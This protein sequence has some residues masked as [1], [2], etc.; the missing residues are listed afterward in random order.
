MNDINMWISL[1][2]AMTALVAVIVGPLIS[3]R[4]AKREV[5]SPIRQ[6]WINVLRAKLAEIMSTSH[7]FFVAWP[8]DVSAESE[9][10]ETETHKKMLFLYREIE[11]MLNPKEHDHT[12]LL[13][14]LR[15]ITFEVNHRET[16]AKYSNIMGET[17]AI[18]QKIFKDE[19]TRVK[20]G[21]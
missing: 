13:E 2:S 12:K 20:Q 6:Q 3:W 7:H 4:I 11:L 14:S 15:K 5:V 16:A 18:A 9:Q 17:T 10:M 21:K 1:I 19:W 8:E